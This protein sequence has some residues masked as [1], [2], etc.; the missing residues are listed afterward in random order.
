ML[1]S[2]FYIF[3]D[4]FYAKKTHFL[5]TCFR[6]HVLHV[7][8]VLNTW[9]TQISVHTLNYINLSVPVKHVLHVQDTF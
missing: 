7:K 9:D 5:K 6:K 3:Q 8:Y 4:T 1:K 2:R